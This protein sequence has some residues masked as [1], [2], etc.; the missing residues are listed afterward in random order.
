M[1][2]DRLNG[3]AVDRFFDEKARDGISAGNARD[4]TAQQYAGAF[5]DDALED[6]SC[7]RAGAD[8]RAELIA[9]LLKGGGHIQSRPGR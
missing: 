4:C 8:Q 3:D 2:D 6:L 1:E 5:D 7:R 9:S